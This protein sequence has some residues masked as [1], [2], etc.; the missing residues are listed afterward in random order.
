MF[1]NKKIKRNSKNIWFTETR[2]SYLPCDVRGWLTYIPYLTYLVFVVAVSI[3]ETD[4]AM[5][6]LVY[7]VP[8]WVAATVVM[9]YV[10]AHKS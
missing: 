2:G 1:M 5:L 4:S 9:T 8:N 3:H 10:A 7:I 6:A